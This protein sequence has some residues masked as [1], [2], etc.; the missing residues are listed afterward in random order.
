MTTP[1]TPT[2][3]LVAVSWLRS[4]SG[5]DD[6]ATTVPDP[7]RWTAD[8]FVA[9]TVVGGTV[10]HAVPIR[11]PVLQLDCYARR[12]GTSERPAWNRANLLAETIRLA[13]YSVA[14]LTLPMYVAGYAPVLLSSA[15]WL[16]EP[17]RMVSDPGFLARY[18]AD[19]QLVYTVPGETA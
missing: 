8:T 11:A 16:T 1:L 17:R 4:L 10:D 2:A 15:T 13:S 7:D 6:A 18:S 19:M 5:V 3:E 14:A 12:P 9:V